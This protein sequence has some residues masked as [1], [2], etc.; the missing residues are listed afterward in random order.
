MKIL[1]IWV[2]SFLLAGIIVS[3][4]F[5]LKFLKQKSVWKYIFWSSALTI[6]IFLLF[7][8][9]VYKYIGNILVRGNSD[10]YFFYDDVSFFAIILINFL[11]I[12]SPIIFTKIAF[13][14][15]K[16]KS[17]FISVLLSFLLFVIYAL[18]FVYILLPEAFSELNRR[19]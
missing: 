8:F 4:F 6:G 12:I 13:G 7:I 1:F 18:V 3:P 2:S 14:K 9:Y 16:L 17:F 15:I 11:I 5:W 10:I 19:L